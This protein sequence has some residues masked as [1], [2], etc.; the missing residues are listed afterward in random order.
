[1]FKVVDGMG[2]QVTEVAMLVFFPDSS[3]C[4]SD[5]QSQLELII[6]PL[7]QFIN[8]SALDVFWDARCCLYPGLER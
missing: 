8:I 3:P 4:T 6:S 2:R 5:D 1:M 7:R